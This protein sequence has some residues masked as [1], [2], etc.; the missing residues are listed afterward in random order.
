MQNIHN[1]FTIHNIQYQGQYGLEL[2]EILGIP[3]HLTSVLEYDGDLNFMKAA[4]ETAEKVTTV[5]PTYAKE[6]FDPWFSHA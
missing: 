1:V 6:I 4:I 3:R 2:L 5:S